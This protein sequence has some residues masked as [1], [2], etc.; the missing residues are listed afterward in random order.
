MVDYSALQTANPLGSL[1]AGLNAGTGIRQQRSRQNA[2]ARYAQG[3]AEGAAQEFAAAGDMES[4]QAMRTQAE[5]AATRTRRA[6]ILAAYQKDP[7]A[8]HDAAIASQDFDLDKALAG[9]DERTAAE[10]A[11]RAESQAGYALGLGDLPYEQRKAKI[12]A[13]KQDLLGM[14]FTEDKI[15]HFDPTDGNLK[16]LVGAVLD[17]KTRVEQRAQDLQRDYERS[18]PDWHER[19]HADGS[20]EFVDLNPTNAGKGEAAPAPSE[21]GQGDYGPTKAPSGGVYGVVSKFAGD[22]GASPQETTY[23][24]R[25]AQVESDGNPSAENGRSTGIFQFRP[26]TFAAAGGKGDIYDVGEQ[27]RAA[28]TL[29]RRDRANLESLGIEPTDANVYIMHQQGPGGGRALLTAPP[30]TGAVAALTPVYG[31]AE[32]ARKAIVGNGGKPDMTAGEFVDMWRRKWAGAGAA[33]ATPAAATA[34]DGGAP[35][36]LPAAGFLPGSLHLNPSIA[37]KVAAGAPRP[38]A[39]GE[40]VANPDGSWSSEISMTVVNPELNGGKP[41]NIPSLWVVNGKAYRAQS[42]D[43]AAALAV[44]SGLSWPAF[45]SVE[46]A[47]KAASDREAKWQ[48]LKPEQASSIPPLWSPQGARPSGVTTQP[49][50]AQPPAR[51]AG[52]PTV[53][54]SAPQPKDPPSGYRWAADGSLEAI[55]GGP[56]DPAVRSMGTGLRREFANLRKEFNSLDEVKNFKDVS[57][58]YR[59]VSSLAQK[60]GATSADDTALTFSFMKMLDPG[61]VVREGEFALVGKSAGLPD[62][63]VMALQRVDEGKALTPT[64]RAKLRETA[65]TIMLQRRAAYD[66]QARNYRAIATDMG[67]NPDQL[68]EDPALWHSR[69]KPEGRAAARAVSAPQGAIDYLR[70]NPSLAADFDAKY[71]KGAAAQVLGTK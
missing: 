10:A 31:S 58:S 63:I 40:Y 66:A 36:D 61:S 51:P 68:A 43:E 30:E 50:A 46:I 28:L 29:S 37:P 24:Q 34:Q 5:A 56:G 57:A 35:R 6:E 64:I 55:K 38:F 9:L 26:D 62:Q 69:I 47:D 71:G 23:L 3:D 41:T 14:G 44:R 25:L 18:K 2:L 12:Q 53:Q 60:P 70:Q 17:I 52:P 32:I 11:K 7:K 1:V 67:A 19:K 21:A 4:A 54:G 20:S 15:D 59:Q 16:G 13:D 22:A 33:S 65:A 8:G 49:A 42:E 45:A 48:G 39:P 27:T